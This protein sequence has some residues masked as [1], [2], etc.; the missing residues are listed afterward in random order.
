MRI[1]SSVC[2]ETL[3]GWLPIGACKRWAEAPERASERRLAYCVPMCNSKAPAPATAP[4]SRTI[5]G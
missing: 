1:W 2:A 3:L 5:V 4:E